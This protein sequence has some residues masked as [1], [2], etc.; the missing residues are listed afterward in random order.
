MFGS[1][2]LRRRDLRVSAGDRFFMYTDGLIEASPGGGR[3]EG[4]GRLVEACV[5]HRTAPLAESVAG[6]ADELRPAENVVEDD[7]L[8]MAAEVSS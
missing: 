1:A 7:L 3:R 6:I 8:L 2:I 4:L 5:R